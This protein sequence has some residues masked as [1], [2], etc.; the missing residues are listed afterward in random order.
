MLAGGE[1]LGMS[2]GQL[3]TSAW[4]GQGHLLSQAFHPLQECVICFQRCVPN[5]R[6]V[7]EQ[8]SSDPRWHSCGIVCSPGWCVT[9]SPLASS[10]VKAHSV[11]SAG[12]GFLCAAIYCKRLMLATAG[13]M[14]YNWVAKWARSHF[15]PS[16]WFILS[17][18][19]N[20]EEDIAFIIVIFDF[21]NLLSL[22][23]FFLFL[24]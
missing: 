1:P 14:F 6:S 9:V 18:C 12:V 16:L 5:H 3:E 19:C 11:Q 13:P 15:V 8:C 20:L 22:V 2:E 7:R 4:A 21:L 23:S 24:W 10:I 17:F